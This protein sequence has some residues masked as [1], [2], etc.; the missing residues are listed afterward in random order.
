VVAVV[1]LVALV[2]AVQQTIRQLLRW[3][4]QEMAGLA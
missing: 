1:V 4:P 2:R 3:F